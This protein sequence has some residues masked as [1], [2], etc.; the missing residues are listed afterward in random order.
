[1]STFGA[2]PP[3][4]ASLPPL[5]LAAGVDLYLT[6]LFLGAAPTLG[7]WGTPPGALG[8]LHSP[9]VLVMVGS[10]YVLEFLAER[11]PSG[12]LFWNAFHAIIRPLAG[13]LLALLLLDGASPQV[14]GAGAVVAGALAA[15]AHATRTG[16]GVLQWLDSS[17]HPN[18][19]L[20]SLLEDVSVVGMVALVL[21]SPRWAL[22]ASAVVIVVSSPVVGSQVRAFAFAVRLV[23]GRVWLTL[24]QPRWDDPEAFPGWVRSAVQGDVMAPGGGLRGGPAAGHRL[25]GAPRFSTGWV[26]VRGDTP[27]FV[28]PRRRRGTG[29]VD[30]GAL[31][32]TDVSQSA[33]FRRVKL[34]G[35]VPANLYFGLDGPGTESLRAEFLLDR[36]GSGTGVS[37]GG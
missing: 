34:Q 25:P 11:W 35:P 28:F 23:W 26:V 36:P 13:A 16:G 12:A 22:G 21:E 19:L 18:R 5:A 2:A 37:R 9:G 7:L 29:R 17:A 4:L 32:A 20:V 27:L 1:L 31:R 3:E 14:T 30:L 24:G 8:E 33:F 15:G 6:L 10:F